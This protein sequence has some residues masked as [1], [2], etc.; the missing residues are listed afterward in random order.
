[1]NS[2]E[3]M[4]TTLLWRNSRQCCSVS[5]CAIMVPAE[6]TVNRMIRQT[7]NLITGSRIAAALL[8]LF[9]TPLTGAFYALYLWCGVSDMVDGTIARRTHSESRIGERQ[10]GGC[11]VSGG[12]CDPAGTGNP[13][14]GL[15]VGLDFPDCG[16][17]SGSSSVVCRARKTTAGSAHHPEQNYGI[18]DLFD[19]ACDADGTGDCAGLHCGGIGDRSCDSGC[20]CSGNKT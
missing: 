20:G 16:G 2:K 18:S 5:L 19:S 11:A 1:M 13:V 12:L 9:A 6:R 4:E 10:C 14:S 8:L 17:K 15:D 3:Y 7:A